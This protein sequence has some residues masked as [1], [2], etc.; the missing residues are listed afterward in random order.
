MMFVCTCG[1]GEEKQNRGNKYKLQSITFIATNLHVFLTEI[2][3]LFKLN[4][5]VFVALTVLD[6]VL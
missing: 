3:S 5:A 4:E 6:F 2:A 1:C